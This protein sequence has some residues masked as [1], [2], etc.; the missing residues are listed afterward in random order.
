MFATSFSYNKR[1]RTLCVYHIYYH[2]IYKYVACSLEATRKHAFEARFKESLHMMVM[3]CSFLF[4]IGLS[5]KFFISCTWSAAAVVCANLLLSPKL[6]F[7]G[8]SGQ[9]ER[10][11]AT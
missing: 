1:G 11:N 9:K 7:R 2:N 3:V 8:L 4:P 10:Q 6:A 5:G